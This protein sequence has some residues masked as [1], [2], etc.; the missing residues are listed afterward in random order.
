MGRRWYM[1]MSLLLTAMILVL[2]LQKTSGARTL[3]GE[4]WLHKNVVLLHSLQ[5]GPVRSS[6]RNP[7]ST[8]PGRNKGRC[9]L[10]EIHAHAPPLFPK[11]EA[12]R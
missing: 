2:N 11:S 12:A 6:Q 3:E 1:K 10:G 8:V 5:R 7:C 4:Q 9:T